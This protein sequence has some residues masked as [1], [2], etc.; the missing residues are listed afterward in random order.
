VPDLA[1]YW[2]EIRAIERSLPDSLW[3][4]SIEDAL[5]GRVAG[6]I[7]EVAAAVA[8]RLLHAKSHRVA[9]EEEIER[10]KAG[11]DRAKK[12]AVEERLRLQGIAVV[13]VKPK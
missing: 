12:A 9:N 5:R 8:A 7:V 4:V 2:Q 6:V 13:G 11:Q 1:R 10:H 3:M